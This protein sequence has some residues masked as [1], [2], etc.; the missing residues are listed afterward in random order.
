MYVFFSSRTSIVSETKTQTKPIAQSEAPPSPVFV[1][2]A[3]PSIKSHQQTENIAGSATTDGNVSHPEPEF[4]QRIDAGHVTPRRVGFD[5]SQYRSE[6]DKQSY[7]GER[8]EMIGKIQV[9]ENEKYKI[10]MEMANK[11]SELE[12]KVL[13]FQVMLW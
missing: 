5:A 4:H 7:E 8:R 12:T 3:S 1:P 13:Y 6:L 11:L 9:L 10:E 2:S